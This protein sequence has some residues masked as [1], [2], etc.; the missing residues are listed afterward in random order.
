MAVALAERPLPRLEELGV[1]EAL[2][3]DLGV[4]RDLEVDR[5]GAGDA[6]R[7]S[8]KTTGDRHFVLVEPASFCG[9]VKATTGAQPTTMAQGIG[10]PSFWYLRQC[11]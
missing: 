1:D 9:P 2:H 11:R 4:G 3:D 6:H 10:C 7:P 5:L 8:G